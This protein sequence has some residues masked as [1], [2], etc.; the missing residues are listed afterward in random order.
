MNPFAPWLIRRDVLGSSPPGR[1]WFGDAWRIV[2]LA[3]VLFSLGGTRVGALTIATY[4][5]ENYV[6]AD[7]MTASGYRQAYPKSEAQKRALRR[8]IRDLGADVLVLQ[9]MGSQPFL[10]ELQRDLRTEGVDYPFTALAVADDTD[11]HVAVLSRRPLRKVTTHRDLSLAYFGAR[12]KVKRGMLEVTIDTAA[13]DVTL[14]AVH[15]KSRFTDRPDD[16]ASALR[17][18]GEAMAIRDRILQRFPSPAD[19]RLII[20]G[21][22]NDGPRSRPLAA[23]QN[24]GRTSIAELL[25]AADSRGETWTHAFR[26]DDSYS[27]ADY[28]LV[29]AGLKP[30]VRGGVARIYDGPGVKEASDHRP[31]FLV[32]IEP[33]K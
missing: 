30:Q 6:L 5:V 22:C 7:R 32:L 13:G 33:E 2:L 23:L 19:A 29:S 12:E 28:M 17:R 10:D 14:F 16:P 20:L 18:A 15:L 11:R 27:R 26:R 25:A 1:V 3:I 9:E 24:R 31:V 8:V 4:N 21:D